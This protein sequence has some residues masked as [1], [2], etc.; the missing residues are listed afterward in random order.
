MRG[1]DV[2]PAED[3]LGEGRERGG[4][5]AG[6]RKGWGWR[7]RARSK[8]CTAHWDGGGAGGRCEP[9]EVAVPRL[10]DCDREDICRIK[11]AE[12]WDL[13]PQHILDVDGAHAAG[14]DRDRDIHPVGYV[15]RRE[16]VPVPA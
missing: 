14:V 1:A 7:K 13:S 4:R 2:A 8:V 16:R 12:V 5:E 9:A 15:E 3:W 6:D 10:V 11:R